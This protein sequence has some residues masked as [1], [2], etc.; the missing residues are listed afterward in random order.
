MSWKD[1]P[2]MLKTL[3]LSNNFVF[4]D[5][6]GCLTDLKA[7]N[8]K[9]L[10]GEVIQRR[11]SIFVINAIFIKPYSMKKINSELN[12]IK[13]KYFNSKNVVL[14]N[15][16]IDNKK[17]IFSNLND[18]EYSSFCGELNEVILKNK[19]Y[20]TSTGLNKKVFIEDMIKS[21]P[22]DQGKITRIIYNSIFK[23]I[24]YMLANEKVH[25]TIIAEESSSPNL[26]KIIVEIL[27]SL[28][29]K[30]K[31][32]NIDGIYFVSKRGASY[33]TGNEIVDM[34]AAPIYRVYQNVEFVSLLKK[35]Y[36]FP[37]GKYNSLQYIIYDSRLIHKV[38]NN[39]LR[40]KNQ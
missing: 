4:M 10:K 14:H 3:N 35:M 2:T 29:K 13:L 9:I 28:K 27:S 26:D 31:I 5:E 8:K 16:E 23:K 30:H 18:D 33:P 21:E 25:A 22:F 36:K 34:T 6:S 24:D 19:F 17:G 11:D 38:K 39:K 7:V 32:K 40:Q 15:T 20:Q 37:R 12:K 1:K